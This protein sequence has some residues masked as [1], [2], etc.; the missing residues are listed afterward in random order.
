[1]PAG[2]ISESHYPVL[3][4]GGNP[5]SN[6]IGGEGVTFNFDPAVLAAILGLFGIGL[7]YIVNLLKN[8]FKVSEKPAVLLVLIVSFVAT[9][10]VLLA[11]GAFT[12]LGL[13]VYTAAVFGE[14]TGWY[15]LTK[16]PA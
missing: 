5:G 3:T 7:V 12:W 15:K 6:L 10:G 11:T 1:L 16:K 14:M 4:A 8:L 13:L 2:N 9:A